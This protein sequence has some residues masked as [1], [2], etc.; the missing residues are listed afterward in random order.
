MTC[1]RKELILMFMMALAANSTWHSPE[2]ILQQAEDLA[3]QYLGA[4]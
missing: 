3:D 4:L 2:V 1:T